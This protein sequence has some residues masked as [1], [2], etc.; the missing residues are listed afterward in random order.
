MLGSS[1]PLWPYWHL[2]PDPTGPLIQELMSELIH[3]QNQSLSHRNKYIQI[4]LTY[5]HPFKEVP[6][7][8]QRFQLGECYRPAMICYSR[9]QCGIFKEKLPEY[10]VL[11]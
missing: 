4:L 2:N 11:Q 6:R 1:L 7:S 5:F 8:F 9:S 10:P 3:H